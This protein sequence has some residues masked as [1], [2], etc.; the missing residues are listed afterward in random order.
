M[1]NDARL[2]LKLAS[3]LLEYPGHPAFWP[4][5][6]ERGPLADAIDHVVSVTGAAPRRIV[7]IGGGAKSAAIRA[8]AP[9][10]F[11]VPVT[12]P[13]PAEYVALGAAPQAAWALSGT[14]SGPAAGLP[15]WPLA[16]ARTH[17]A[18]PQPLVRQHY[19]ALRDDS[20][21]WQA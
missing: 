21:A 13:E 18:E 17:D 11:G 16:A 3:G 2:A 12:V 4:R 5:L 19:A 15:E 1:R 6:V 8:L 20:A 7:L 9:A 14:G 10:I